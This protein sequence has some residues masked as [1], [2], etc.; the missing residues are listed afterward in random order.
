MGG[1]RLRVALAIAGVVALGVASRTVRLDI[2]VWGT[3]LGDALYAMAFYLALSFALPQ[4]VVAPKALAVGLFCAAVEL[5]QLTGI[6]GSLGASESAAVRLFAYAVL[7][8][9]FSWADMLAYAAGVG[10]VGLLD[11]RGLRRERG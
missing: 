3:Q 4:L 7:G 8:S 10:L 9:G 6:P 1:Y 11:G 2:P 5:F